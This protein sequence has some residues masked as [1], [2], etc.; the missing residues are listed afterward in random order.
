M[1]ISAAMK[2][3]AILVAHWVEVIDLAR[4]DRFRLAD[5]CPKP[6]PNLRIR[7]RARASLAILGR[8]R[9]YSAARADMDRTEGP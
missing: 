1:T 5:D 9:A 6:P 7:R 8:G 2:A 4:V 3:R